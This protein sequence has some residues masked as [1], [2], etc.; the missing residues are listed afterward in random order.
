MNPEED[1]W[2]RTPD[3]CP[4]PHAPASPPGSG[5]CAQRQQA[6]RE[7]GTVARDP[8][9]MSSSERLREV[10][11]LLAAGYLRLSKSR[12]KTLEH[13]HR[14]VALM[15]PVNGPETGPGKDDTWNPA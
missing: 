1:S 8:A 10:A 3:E 13:A 14:D 9:C 7:A 11:F 2:R 12:R 4:N 6:P 5:S 15:V